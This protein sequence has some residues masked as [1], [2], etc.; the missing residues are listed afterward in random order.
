MDANVHYCTCIWD[1][2]KWYRQHI[3]LILCRLSCPWLL[4]YEVLRYVTRITRR[5][6]TSCFLPELRKRQSV[7]HSHSHS[8]VRGSNCGRPELLLFPARD[9]KLRHTRSYS[10][11]FI[12]LF[13]YPSPCSSSSFSSCFTL[14]SPSLFIPFLFSYFSLYKLLYFCT[15]WRSDSN[16]HT[17][18]RGMTPCRPLQN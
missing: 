8:A 7:S 1:K 14:F 10:Y 12:F 11:C 9:R 6:M 4:N 5:N 3:L 2:S 13:I 16:K 18:T 17:T 15:I